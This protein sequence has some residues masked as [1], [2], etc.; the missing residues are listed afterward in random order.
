MDVKQKLSEQGFVFIPKWKTEKTIVELANTLGD[1]L[2][3]SDYFN[4]SMI[5]DVQVIRPKKKV[6]SSVNQYSGKFGLNAFPLH[7]DL[8]H[9]NQPPN[10]LMLRCVKGV[11]R[12][13]TKILPL[14]VVWEM[15]QISGIG[16]AIVKS[17]GRQ[18]CMLPLL[19]KANEKCCIRWD[20]YFLEPMNENA[21]A[22]KRLMLSE[23]VWDLAI[24][25]SLV[26]FGD[27]LILNNHSILHARS[28]VPIECTERA[29]E[30]V[31][32]N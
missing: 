25:I 29:I 10:Y 27:T 24:D 12:V 9:W 26:D 4:H 8:A 5:Q 1:V 28:N 23:N 22:I 7:T 6:N 20:S 13:T 32:F 2:K 16:R 31:Y 19:F 18:S 11:E 30:R 17:R 14:D 15:L 21:E 3:I